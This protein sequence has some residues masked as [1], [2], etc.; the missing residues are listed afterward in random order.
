MFSIIRDRVHLGFYGVKTRMVTLAFFLIL[1]MLSF[2]TAFFDTY[3]FEYSFF[4]SLK[5][6]FFSEVS[7]GRNIVWTGT[8]IGLMGSIIIDIR[9][10]LNK[11]KPEEN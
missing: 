9:L 5:N 11:K 6:L 7:V 4:S 3:V 8:L 10:K 2:I 1:L